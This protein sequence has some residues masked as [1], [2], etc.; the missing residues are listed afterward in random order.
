MERKMLQ[1]FVVPAQQAASVRL[2]SGQVVR[3]IAIEGP[4]VVDLSFF[5]AHDFSETYRGPFSWGY[6]CRMGT[7]NG[8]T[9]RYFYSRL[10]RANLMLEMIE[11]KVGKHWVMNNGHCN[12]FTNERRGLATASRSCQDNIAGAIAEH[13]MTPDQV[14]DTFALWMNVDENP[15]GEYILKESTAKQG[16]YTDFLAHMD[17]LVAIS[18]CPGSQ[19]GITPINGDRDKPI[20]VQVWEFP[21]YVYLRRPA[22][23]LPTA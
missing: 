23:T 3:F 9:M 4:Q 21:E 13:G 1:E 14:P 2:N 15:D 7:G 17:L 6:N 18:A 10:P 19:D 12:R 20:Q 8:N 22:T 11:D 5:N 16:D